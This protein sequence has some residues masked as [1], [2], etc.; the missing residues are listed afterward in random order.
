M[1]D[2]TSQV[3]LS[4]ELDNKKTNRHLKHLLSSLPLEAVVLQTLSQAGIDR[5]SSCCVA[6]YH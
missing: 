5:A 2:Y 3:E 1:A 4:I 6:D